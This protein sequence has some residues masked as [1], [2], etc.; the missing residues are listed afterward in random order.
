MGFLISTQTLS[1]AWEDAQTIARQLKAGAQALQAEAV[2]GAVVGS[3]ILHF[4]RE[5]RSYRDRLSA[6]AALPG[7]AAYVATLPNTPAGYDVSARFAAMQTEI[8]ATI[9]WVRTNFPASGGYLQERTW[10][11]DGPVER[12]F[13]PAALSA[14]GLGAQLDALIA[15]IG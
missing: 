2:A 13:T 1:Q 9:T 12:T 10:G 7:I 15:A 5:V 11:A 14:A 4:E 3:R 6:L 8:E